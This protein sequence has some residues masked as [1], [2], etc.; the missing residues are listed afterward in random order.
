MPGEPINY[1]NESSANI[2]IRK[3]N[4]KN[5]K[6]KNIYICVYAPFDMVHENE[7]IQCV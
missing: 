6:Q 5:F 2:E 1:G 4:K 3:N 7:R